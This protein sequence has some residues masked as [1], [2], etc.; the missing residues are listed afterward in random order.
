MP[1]RAIRSICWTLGLACFILIGL[2]VRDELSF[3]FD[4]GSHVGWPVDLEVVARPAGGNAVDVG[5]APAEKPARQH[6]RDGVPGDEAVQQRFF[7]EH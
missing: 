6:L 3:R 1:T 4:S 2:W 5:I 7:V